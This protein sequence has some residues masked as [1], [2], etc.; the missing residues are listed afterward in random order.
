VKVI[1]ID[2]GI[3]V[4]G[5]GIIEEE[6]V[7][8]RGVIKPVGETTG[9]RL[10]SLFSQISIILE[11]EKPEYAVLEEIIYHKNPKTFFLLGAARGVT[12]LA[13]EE[14]KVPVFEISPTKVKLAV[15]GNGRARKDQVAFMVKKLL[16]IEDELSH[17]ITD[18]LACAIAFM[19]KRDVIRY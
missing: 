16:D 3:L 8:K 19:R 4:T 7:L 15:T 10:K 2:P 6:R 5:Y 18:A 17:H 9:E 11:E 14:K 13:L 12:L 1:G